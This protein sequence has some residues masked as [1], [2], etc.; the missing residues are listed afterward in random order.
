[1]STPVP[2]I[3]FAYARPAHLARV[4]ACL[5]ENRVPLI[6]AYADGPKG[7]ADAAAVAEVRALL[8]AVDWAE[9]R[10]VERPANLGLGRSVRAGVTEVAAQHEA[11]I[12]WEDDL[13]AVPGTYAW[14]CAALGQYAQEERVMSVSAWTHPRVTPA[15]RRAAPYFDARAE[16]WVWGSW[17]RAWAGMND[18]DARAKLG[19]AAAR[20]LAADA[21]GSDLPAMAEQ[22]SDKNLWAVRWLYHHFARGGLCL[23]PPWSMVEHIGFDPQ[24]TN[25][26]D[27]TS[28]ANPPLRAAPPVPAAWPEPVE[29]PHC[30][31]LWSAEAAAPARTSGS[32]LRKAARRILP[33]AWLDPFVARNFRVRWTGDYADWDAARAAG[34]GYEATAILDR[35]QRAS[36]QVRDGHAGYERD[37][38][39]FA[40]T[41]PWTPALTVLR[42]M[43]AARPGPIRV[44]DF[45]GS[46]GSGYRRLRAR[47]PSDQPLHWTVVEQPGFV[48]AGREFKNA[49]LTFR[50][51]IAEA[52]A[53]GVPDAVLLSSVLSYLPDPWETLA[54]LVALGAG[55]IVV[56]GTGFTIGGG[57]RLA[58]QHVPRSIY[59]ASYP[60]WFLDRAE[61]LGVLR[62]RYELAWELGAPGPAPEGCEFRSLVLE[63]KTAGEGGR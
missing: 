61:F 7:G 11:F 41:P 54:E 16:C 37:G 14:I 36:R 22:E 57:R 21:Y 27:A 28:W 38:V 32:L 59:R 2:V 39:V 44:L 3:L 30:R 52:V 51:T 33:A 63:R 42:E 60:C 50:A 24:A 20:G 17:A 4:L 35:V 56:E 31:A 26:A 48:A 49:E 1:M 58:V 23:R 40:G 10:L 62:P 5:R 8:R 15:G 43:A 12:V 46:L 6:L 18:A 25:A 19:Q 55:T 45:G 47:L 53:A 13:V 29:H 34:G 9:L